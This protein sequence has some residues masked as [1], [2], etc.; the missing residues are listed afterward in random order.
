MFS[1]FYLSYHTW[2]KI[3]GLASFLSTL[4]LECHFSKMHDRSRDLVRIL[5]FSQAEA[6]SIEG[7][8][9]KFQL[10][11]VVNGVYFCFALNQKIIKY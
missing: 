6:K 1:V 4:C 11:V 3:I 9:S 8:I 5:L 7:S 2:N 10:F